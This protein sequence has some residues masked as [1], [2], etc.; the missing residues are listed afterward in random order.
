MAL[1]DYVNEKYGNQTLNSLSIKDLVTLFDRSS[2][3]LFQ[4]GTVRPFA[5]IGRDEQGNLVPINA[6]GDITAEVTR[7]RVVSDIGVERPLVN[8][9]SFDLIV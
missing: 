3:A 6:R 2:E 8:L 9:V 1:R 5:L 7:T 4:P